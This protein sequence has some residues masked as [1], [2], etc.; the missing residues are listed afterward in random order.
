MTASTELLPENSTRPPASAR[1]WT[2][3]LLPPWLRR[4]LSSSSA[5]FSAPT[6]LPL[7]AFDAC[8]M[9]L[10]E[11]HTWTERG[12]N[13]TA[14]CLVPAAS[15]RSRVDSATHASMRWRFASPLC[16]LPWAFAPKLHACARTHE[17]GAACSLCSRVLSVLLV[18]S[19][20][21]CPVV[22][23]KWCY[24][25]LSRYSLSSLASPPSCHPLLPSPPPR[26][27]LHQV[28][29]RCASACLFALLAKL[30]PGPIGF[31]CYFSEDHLC[32]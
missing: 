10:R 7:V 9:R 27:T 23:L 11:A 24:R 31:S 32:P 1:C 29:D 17:D 14:R 3:C 16:T 13:P 6:L 28:T 12:G 22:L 21:L 8:C 2:W 5:A 18:A 15:H 19:R 26:R 30:Y 25:H 20:S 4:K